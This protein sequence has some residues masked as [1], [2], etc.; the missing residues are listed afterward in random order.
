VKLKTAY[1]DILVKELNSREARVEKH[2]ELH[3]YLKTPGLAAGAMCLFAFV[4][5]LKD[6]TDLR[7]L[8]GFIKIT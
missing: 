2:G 8:S 4:N 3:G 1:H 7:G 5:C 6:K